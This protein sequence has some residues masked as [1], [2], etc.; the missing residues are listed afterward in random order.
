M[1]CSKV[2]KNS[3]FKQLYPFSKNFGIL[4]VGGLLGHSI[5]AYD[6]KYLI[7]LAN[8]C[9]LNNMILNYLHCGS[10]IYCF[11]FEKIFGL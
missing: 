9:E 2:Y 5:L 3:K 6:E 1:S 11:M 7:L 10:D 4:R 8:N